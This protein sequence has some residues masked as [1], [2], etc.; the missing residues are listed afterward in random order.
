MVLG[1]RLVPDSCTGMSKSRVDLLLVARGLVESRERARALIMAG[2]VFS[3]ER[4]IEKPGETLKT[5]AQLE[6]RGR[7]HPWVSRG[8]VKL[9]HAHDYFCL[10]PSGAVALDIGASTGGFT[11]VLLQHG[12][13]RVYAVDVGYGQIAWKLREDERV[14]VLER[15]N[16]RRLTRV[17]VPEEVNFITCDVSFIGLELIL[18][19]PLALAA[20]DATL[21]TLIKPQFEVGPKRVG[22]GGVVREPALHQE[23][24]QRIKSWLGF[25]SGWR[26]LGI[27]DSPILGPAGNKEYLLAARKG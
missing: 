14:V 13:V 20:S 11:D 2:L 8:G 27:T 12:A 17:Q 21:I 25:Q 22:R 19:A 10:N 24:C 3:D 6:T 9:A 16:A 23:V 1:S 26:V 7:S 4:R 5:D 18:P 15:T